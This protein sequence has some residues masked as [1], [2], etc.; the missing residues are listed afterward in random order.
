MRLLATLKVLSASATLFSLYE[1]C[2]SLHSA[3]LVSF[4]NLY[5]LTNVSKGGSFPSLVFI[6]TFVC[7]NCTNDG[8]CVIN[9]LFICSLVFLL[10]PFTRHKLPWGPWPWLLFPHSVPSS[11]HKEVVGC[12]VSSE[13]PLPDHSIAS[14]LDVVPTLPTILPS[15]HTGLPLF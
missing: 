13:S 1:L 10:F 6:S 2:S 14:L 9:Y 15:L 3:Q 8:P 12:H 7:F 5:S 11:W 4:Q